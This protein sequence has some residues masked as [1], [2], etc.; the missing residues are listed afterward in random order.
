MFHVSDD[1]ATLKFAGGKLKIENFKKIFP[2]EKHEE[3]SQG[4]KRSADVEKSPA[5]KLKKG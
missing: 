2:L 3:A 1:E 4:T 5:K